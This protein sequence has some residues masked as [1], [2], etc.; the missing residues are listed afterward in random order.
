M[1]MYYDKSRDSHFYVH[2]FITYLIMNANIL[3]L[4]YISNSITIY[5]INL[6]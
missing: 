6:Y 3:Q 2:F 5:F 4:N 1:Y